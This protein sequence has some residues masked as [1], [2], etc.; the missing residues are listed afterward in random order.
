MVVNYCLGHRPYLFELIKVR[1]QFPTLFKISNRIKTLIRAKVIIFNRVYIAVGPEVHLLGPT[2]GC[3]QLPKMNHEETLVCMSILTGYHPPC[4]Y[5]RK[6]PFGKRPV[7]HSP[8]CMFQSMIGQPATRLV[9]V[10]MS[11]IEGL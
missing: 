8:I 2:F 3:I 1:A 4:Q 10:L 5:L 6:Y 11:L 7:R 9:K